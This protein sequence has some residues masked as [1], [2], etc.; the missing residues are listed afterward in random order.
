MP[1]FLAVLALLLQNLGM[2][3][4]TNP[5]GVKNGP[6]P[7]SHLYLDQTAGYAE[8]SGRSSNNASGDL[9]WEWIIQDYTTHD[10]TASSVVTSTSG[11]VF[12]AGSY[13]GDY[14]SEPTT[15]HLIGNCELP[16]ATKFFV[17]KFSI[18]GQCLLSANVTGSS[19]FGVVR[20]GS[21]YA[22]SLSDV[23]PIDISID[24]SNNV[25][26]AGTVHFINT[27][28]QH[29]LTFGEQQLNNACKQDSCDIGFVA[30]L[31]SSGQWEW[32][33]TASSQESTKHNIISFTALDTDTNGTSII[34]GYFW[35]NAN[36]G[37]HVVQK[38]GYPSD[39]FI[40]KIDSSGNW[41]W[42]EEAGCDGDHYP[43]P[44]WVNDLIIATDGSVFVT[45]L[46][47]CPVGY[48]IVFGSQRF[49]LPIS[50]S[51]IFTAKI[52]AAG[53][54]EWATSWDTSTAASTGTSIAYDSNNDLY[55]VGS[56]TGDVTANSTTVSASSSVNSG[57]LA[58]LHQNGTWDW[59]KAFGTGTTPIGIKSVTI[60]VD[61]N[62][63]ITGSYASQFT[64]GNL[65]LSP[66]AGS[67]DI[68]VAKMSPNERWMF[69]IGAGSAG[70]DVS[71]SITTDGLGNAYLVGTVEGSSSYGSLSTVRTSGKDWFLTRLSGDYDGDII[72][73]I[74]D[75][76]D[77]GDYISDKDDLC[78]FSPPDF[79]SR[80]GND[81]DAD[82]C[83]DSDEDDDD[84]ND[85]VHDNDD[86]CS[87]GQTGW[88]SNNMTDIDS[89]GCLDGTEDYDDDGDGIEDFED[90]CQRIPGNSTMQQEKG[91]PDSDGDGRAD[92]LDPFPNNASEW[93]D[94]D[95]DGVGDN[96]DEFP[97]DI[98]Q[99]L[100]TDGDGYGD[101]EF[102]NGGDSCP[103]I[104]GNS[105]TDRLG[106]IDSDGDGWSDANDDFPDNPDLY[107]DTDGD[108][109]PDASDAFPYDPT[110]TKDS[111]GDGYGDNANGNLGDSFP[112][113]PLRHADS[114]SDGVDDG[115][116]A[117][118]YDP[119][120]T[121]DSDGDGMGDNPMGVGADKFPNDPT[122]WGDI[123]GD[124]YGDNATG[125]NADAFITDP[126]Q[127]SDA[128]G[129]GY[130][131]NPAGRLADAF[132][133]NPTQWEDLDGDGLGDNQSGTEADPYLDDFD[134]DGYND[135]IDILPKFA[136]PG[137][138]DGDGCLDEDDA[139]PSDARECSDADGDGV[140]DNADADDDNDGALDTEEAIAGTNQ[141]S[142]SSK[143]IESF[144]IILPGTSIGLGAWDIIGMFAGIPAFTYLALM[145]STRSPRVRRFEEDL[146]EARS[147]AELADISARYERA[148]LF[149]LIGPHH[150][151]RLE[152]IRS[153]L[154]NRFESTAQGVSGGDMWTAGLDT[155][156]APDT[157]GSAPS[158]DQ[159]G[160]V[161]SDGYEWLSHGGAQYYRA[162]HSGQEW[163]RW[164]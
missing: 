67:S 72:P 1:L 84:D 36:F 126:T 20:A 124:G 78:N 82:G 93:Q 59:I 90:L 16:S 99:Q 121:V 160:Q 7:S 127:W 71:E 30:K 41:L 150:G 10:F 112:Y 58:K 65:Q 151:L 97:F 132:P 164:G 141:F 142:S 119:S 110:Q 138:L 24:A 79:Q 51:S 11:E 13:D 68:F 62:V 117:F 77:D 159:M 118:P 140:G 161:S 34:G 163:T 15:A 27:G 81:H 29:H 54:W 14:A 116:D 5:K 95:G 94:S 143:P 48:E 55:V 12:V 43:S 40:A 26:V 130:G 105:T 6:I 52:S 57:F 47:E 28:T 60:D 147:E 103:E 33:R 120:Q 3:V 63:L 108:M 80:S 66:I 85:N 122:Q 19:Y 123:D 2:M 162:P 131:D 137:D 113:D 158:A 56:M 135:S 83:R 134:N 107:L 22:G 53:V 86:S 144:E 156:S 157:S 75:E 102:G 31:N 101:Q 114:D 139:F 8:S 49:N 89:D 98:T 4:E 88:V 18:G 76:D 64:V 23:G 35:N 37:T 70:S 32:V 38:V 145:I 92:I 109:I 87:R 74:L 104:H 17:L 42:A 136:S 154:E 100:D 133:T 111:D 44:D 146:Y 9:G 129:D 148:M 149:R 69:A 50:Q 96:L 61:D 25:Y 73:D 46:I 106:C 153:K 155:S 128:D 45:G 91:C 125:N 21:H 152:R 39:I 115:T